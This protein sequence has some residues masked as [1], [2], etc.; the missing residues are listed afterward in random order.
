MKKFMLSFQEEQELRENEKAQEEEQQDEAPKRKAEKPSES[1]GLGINA[2]QKKQM[3]NEAFGRIVEDADLFAA[4]RESLGGLF[5]NESESDNIARDMMAVAADQVRGCLGKRIE[6]GMLLERAQALFDE[7]RN[8]ARDSQLAGA[9]ELAEQLG[10]KQEG[11][12]EQGSAPSE[13][14]GA[15]PAAPGGLAGL[16]STQGLTGLR[17]SRPRT[18]L[19][20]NFRQEPSRRPLR[21]G[22]REE[23]PRRRGP[24]KRAHFL[25]S[26][27]KED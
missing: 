11:E 21:A 16:P 13:D 27:L 8:A 24:R 18:L 20:K 14:Q 6:D 9:A 15:V 4:F 19:T 10:E 17:S 22:R 12:S 3:T 23:P 25:A 26:Y 2:E 7:C 1:K 5:D